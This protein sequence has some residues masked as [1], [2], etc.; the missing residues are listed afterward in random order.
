L[1]EDAKNA[2]DNKSEE[3]Q[4]KAL[5]KEE[6]K[7]RQDSES[8]DLTEKHTLT[9][10]LSNTSLVNMKIFINYVKFMTYQSILV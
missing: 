1:K 2:R 7:R 9:G 6:N 3:F 10:N 8:A 4:D 5:K